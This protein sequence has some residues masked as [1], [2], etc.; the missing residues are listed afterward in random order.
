[1]KKNNSIKALLFLFTILFSFSINAYNSFKQ[2]LSVSDVSLKTI[3]F[4]APLNSGVTSDDII[5]EELENEDDSEDFLTDAFLLLPFHD[6]AFSSF[7]QKRS[8]NYNNTY[9]QTIASIFISVRSL[10]I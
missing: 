4:N 9:S 2:N 5:F 3:H 1:M 6:L 7:V 10:R 8:A